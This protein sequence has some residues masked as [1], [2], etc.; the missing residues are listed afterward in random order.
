MARRRM[1]AGGAR[2][3]LYGLPAAGSPLARF[4]DAWLGGGEARAAAVPL[5]AGIDAATQRRITAGPALYGLHATLKPPFRLAP[6]R[7]R[8]GLEKAVRTLAAGWP[9]F[10]APPLRLACLGGFLALVLERPSPAMARLAAAAVAGLDSFR[11]PP[12]PQELAR[13]RRAGLDARQRV[14]LARWGYPCVMGAFR[15]HIT[16]TCRLGA[17][18]GA[19]IRRALAPHVAPLCGRFWPMAEIALMRQEAPGAPFVA[20]GR[21]RLAGRSWTRRR[22]VPS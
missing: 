7:D 16:L 21:Y 1:A 14:L 19:A 20:A 18:E 11:A 2:F 6:G 4:G 22:H 12:S 5:V 9:A 17:A 3:A 15:F 10:S 8:A 13:R